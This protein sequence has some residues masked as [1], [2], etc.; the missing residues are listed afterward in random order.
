MTIFRPMSAG[1][2][3]GAFVAAILP[4]SAAIT[5][6]VHVEQGTVSSVAGT[7][8]QVRVF[9]GIPFAAP[10]VGNLRW[11]APKA[12]ANWT[13]VRSGDKFG[14]VC[15]QRRAAELP[16]ID[17]RG[18]PVPQRLHRRQNGARP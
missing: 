17:E 6:P 15:M 18:L 12:P 2:L 11:R 4:V 7:S 9:K 5:Q 14:P 16:G 13:G 8:P 1:T 3:L 10:P